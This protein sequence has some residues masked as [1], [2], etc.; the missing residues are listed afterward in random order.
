MVSFATLLQPGQ[1]LRPLLLVAHQRQLVVCW[2]EN[3][4]T[5]V[6]ARQQLS[7]SCLHMVAQE[8]QRGPQQVA[9]QQPVAA[10]KSAS[11][12]DLSSYS[13][14]ATFRFLRYV[15]LGFRLERIAFIIPPMTLRPDPRASRRREAPLRFPARRRSSPSTGGASPRSV[16]P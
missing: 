7:V 6:L 2:E 3:G 16:P 9:N 12:A 13:S 15:I 14:L 5:R 11:D 8:R 10:P 4:F 1:P